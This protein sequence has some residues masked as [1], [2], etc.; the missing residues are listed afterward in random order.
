VADDPLPALRASDADRERTAELLR[1][2][3]GEGRLDVDE[4]EERLSS[5]YATR[6]QAELDAL[7]ADVIAPEHRDRA[8]RVPVS[9]GDGGTRWLVS[10]MSGHDRKGRWRVGTN[11]NVVNV[12]GGSDID[13]NDA[14]LADDVVTV[15]VF[16][17]MGGASIRV[18]EG[19]NVEV[20]DFALM[21]G[22]DANIGNPLPDPGGPTLRIK[23]ISIMGG[24]DVKRGRRLSREEKRELRRGMRH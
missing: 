4:L 15:T 24:T 16:S 2:A 17:L 11:L 22:N 12:M 14:E 18:P 9:R 19:L 8:P 6:T 5:V 3:A 23:L 21:G 7:V 20:S 10:I 1:H 13:F